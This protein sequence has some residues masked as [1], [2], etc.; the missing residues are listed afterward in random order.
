MFG[1]DEFCLNGETVRRGYPVKLSAGPIARC[2]FYVYDLR[3]RPNRWAGMEKARFDYLA[4]LFRLENKQALRDFAD[5]HLLSPLIVEFDPTTACNFSCPECISGDLLNQGAIPEERIRTL[6]DEFARGGVQGLIFIG[7]GEPLA[8]KSMPQ[9]LTWAKEAGLSV[10][11]TTNG[12]LIERNIDVIAECVDWTRVSIDA[13]TPETFQLFRPSKIPDSFNFILRGMERLSKIKH[14]AMGMS[15]LIIQRQQGLSVITNAHEIY[16]AAK[17]AKEVGCDY[18]EVKP[19]VDQKHF[20]APFDKIIG[21]QVSEQYAEC[22]T[23]EDETFEIVAPGSIKYLAENTNPI[24]PKTYTS[25]PAMELRT[26][27]TPSGIYPCP[28]LRGREDK[29]LGSIDDGPF[30][31][32]WASDARRTAARKTDP[33]RDCSFY[34]IRH[35]T[36]Q[37]LTAVKSLEEQGIPILNHLIQKKNKDVFF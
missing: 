10:G 12:S 31:K 15:F 21:S 6:I 7:G 30:D 4:K 33:S 13:G 36:N 37:A 19:M 34:C 2:N 3:R 16:I 32:F 23:L 11:L 9:P 5:D 27:V 24:Q 29:K 8:H 35:N 20:L 18:F 25:C 28:Y 1:Q 22:L 17:R 26:L 14:G